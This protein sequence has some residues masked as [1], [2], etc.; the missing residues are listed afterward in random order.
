MPLFTSFLFEEDEIKKQFGMLK[1]MTYL[2]SKSLNK[3]QV[4][5]LE[6]ADQY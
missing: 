4:A 1:N 3:K 2:H 5:E 6:R